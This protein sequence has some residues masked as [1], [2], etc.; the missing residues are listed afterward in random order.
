MHK[1]DGK[2][3]TSGTKEWADHNVN[4]IDGCSHD[5]KYCYAKKMAIR[6]KRKTSATWKV[7]HVRQHDVDKGYRKKT[8]RFMFPTSHDIVP[9]EPFFTACM[10][11]L[12]KLLRAGND[13]LVTTKPHLKVVKYICNTFISFKS[14]IQFRFTITSMDDKKLAEWEPGAPKF[15]ERFESM[16]LAFDA[17]YKTSISAEPCLEADPR[18]LIKTLRPFVTESI[19]LGSMNY[20]GG[21]Y[22][23]TSRSNLR[24]WITWFSGDELVRFKDSIEKKLG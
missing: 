11:V 23:F 1:V 7:M 8:G 18:E 15:Q 24:N 13:V 9:A 21:G 14:Q 22:E 5:C 12:E 6:F 10:T 19:W 16:K 2:K 4:L 17:G 20:C 3:I